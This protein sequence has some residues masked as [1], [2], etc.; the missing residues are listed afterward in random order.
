M[1][2]VENSLVSSSTCLIIKSLQGK[3]V[4]PSAFEQSGK[5][6]CKLIDLS[7]YQMSTKLR[8]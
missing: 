6:S 1:S 5:P 7:D 4:K 8:S 3:G 2:F